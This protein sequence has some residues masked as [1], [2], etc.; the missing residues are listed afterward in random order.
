MLNENI[1]RSRKSKGLSQDE[2]AIKL[3]VVRQTVSKWERGLSVPDSEMLISLSKILEI[4]VSILLGETMEE[5]KTDD[6]KAISEKLEVVNLQ[7]AK[8]K[9]SNRRILH[10]IMIVSFIGMLFIFAM[11]LMMNGSYLNWDY[12][13]PELAVA[14]V[15]IH[16]FE[17]IFIRIFP[18]VLIALAIGIIITRK[19]CCK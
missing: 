4:P 13:N 19:K 14:G 17:W 18:I 12:S 2:L 16:G 7:L 8:K 1:K 15:L 10:W 5:S 6:L 9:D 3:N 11:F